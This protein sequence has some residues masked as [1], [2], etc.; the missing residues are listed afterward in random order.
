MTAQVLHSE[1]RRS[2]L[3]KLVENPWFDRVI[4]LIIMLNAVIAALTDPLCEGVF[5]CPSM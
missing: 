4:L 1:Q 5:T 2:S 3:A